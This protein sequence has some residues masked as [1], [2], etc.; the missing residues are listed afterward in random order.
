MLKLKLIDIAVFAH[1]QEGKIKFS[2]SHSL[3]SRFYF[4]DFLSSYI[5]LEVEFDEQFLFPFV[6]WFLYELIVVSALRGIAGKQA[7]GEPDCFFIC[8]DCRFSSFVWWEK[9][10][11]SITAVTEAWVSDYDNKWC[12]VN[13]IYPAAMQA[14]SE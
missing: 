12:I 10:V 4:L 7:C 8:I 5:Y 1:Y 3:S 6:R 9:M 11:G 13:R 14:I 2:L